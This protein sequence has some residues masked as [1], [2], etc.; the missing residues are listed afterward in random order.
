MGG[1]MC[2][3]VS[4]SQSPNSQHARAP[5]S[6]DARAQGSRDARAPGS[7]VSVGSLEI[8]GIVVSLEI[9][10]FPVFFFVK[11]SGKIVKIGFVDSQ[12]QNKILK[13]L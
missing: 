11:K 4:G 2:S 10:V 3:R 7:Q 12:D 1:R 8:P 9:P 6:Q 5:A 13:F